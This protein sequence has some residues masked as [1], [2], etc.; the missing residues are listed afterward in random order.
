MERYTAFAEAIEVGK[1]ERVDELCD[2]L[3]DMTMD[4][5]DNRAACKLPEDYY[6][7]LLFLCVDHG[8]EKLA[9]HL[10]KKGVTYNVAG[11]VRHWNLRSYPFI[12]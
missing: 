3:G 4:E 5:L 12:Y 9:V 8:H 6:R 1:Q 11:R 2:S 10:I 7:P